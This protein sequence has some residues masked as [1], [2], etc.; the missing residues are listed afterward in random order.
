[1]GMNIM[2]Y[3]Q[4]MPEQKPIHVQ[5]TM[6]GM[7][8]D[9]RK[10]NW[11]TGRPSQYS[12]EF[13]GDF[14]IPGFGMMPGAGYGTKSKQ[15]KTIEGVS[16]LVN[17]AADP[18]KNNTTVLNNNPEYDK[19]G[20]GVPDNVQS[21]IIPSTPGAASAYDRNA[22]NMLDVTEV[23]TNLPAVNNNPNKDAVGTGAKVPT[24]TAT[25]KT[26]TA[27][28]SKQ[29]GQSK[30]AASS[31]QTNKG[32]A[33]VTAKSKGFAHLTESGKAPAKASTYDP[34]PEWLKNSITNNSKSNPA[35]A[36]NTI[37][38]RYLNEQQGKLD[39][40]KNVGQSV[41]SLWDLKRVLPGGFESGGFVDSSNPD[42]Y[43]FVYG[44]DDVTTQQDLD[45]TDSRNTGSPFFAKGGLVK[46]EKK[47][48]VKDWDKDGDGVPDNLQ[49]KRIVEEKKE[50][51][52]KPE[53]QAITS[54]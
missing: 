54:K 37:V 35:P 29:A 21:N 8:L 34:V 36:S 16:R 51:A 43:K 10:S 27:T 17:K 7:K 9:V 26:T 19:D 42:L 3:P 46:Y 12:I 38:D 45:Y 53:F 6:P 49:T 33:A 32:K 31:A 25:A 18:G 5:G 23:K 50:E 15:R 48:E 13:G 39:M 30:P 2:T 4:M 22:N 24:K 28:K 52:K 20:N 44:G 40:L 14:A 41:K 47:G 1:M 11:L